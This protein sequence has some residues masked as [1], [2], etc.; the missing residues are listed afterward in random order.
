MSNIYGIV[1]AMLEMRLALV[2]ITVLA[3]NAPDAPVGAEERLQSSDGVPW[4]LDGK[5][6][7][8]DGC[9]A[10]PVLLASSEPPLGRYLDNLDTVK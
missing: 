7:E 10:Q 5:Y 4:W 1:D 3:K 8:P 6:H 9:A 2:T